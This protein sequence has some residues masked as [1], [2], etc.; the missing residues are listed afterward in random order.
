[1]Q[2]PQGCMNYQPQSPRTVAEQGFTAGPA[3]ALP[4]VIG[5][6][7]PH[8]PPRGA[9]RG[10]V[11]EVSRHLRRRTTEAIAAQATVRWIPPPS[12]APTG[13]SSV[14]VDRGT[15]YAA[16]FFQTALAPDAPLT[17]EAFTTCATDDPTADKG[18][19]SGKHRLE[20]TAEVL[21]ATA[22][23]AS[24]FV[25]VE[26]DCAGT[27]DAG[28][29]DAGTPDA[30]TP[31]GLFADT[32]P[33]DPGTPDR[34][35]GHTVRSTRGRPTWAR[36]T[37]P[38]STTA[39]RARSTPARRRRRGPGATATSGRLRPRAADGPRCWSAAASCCAGGVGRR[40]AKA[41]ARGVPAHPGAPA[42]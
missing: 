41:G 24:L 20:V 19:G 4:T 14:R 29:A 10:F 28:T 21:G 26:L 35:I 1:M 32:G 5:T 15:S 18:L 36:R 7:R 33:L 9:A 16:G 3:S 22:R 12:C 30:G 23:P 8:R 13:E 38:L 34:A 2:F 40:E 17:F 27:T 42:Y 25:D 11:G 37:R 39:R 6:A 31:D